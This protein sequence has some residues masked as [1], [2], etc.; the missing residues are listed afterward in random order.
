VSDAA[1]EV[2]RLAA[3]R[4]AA[5]ARRDFAKADELRMRIRALGY[6]PT[7]TS[8]G[9]L[10]S[11]LPPTFDVSVQW[12]VQGWPEDIVRG[13]ES[14]RTNEGGRSVQHVVVATELEGFGWPDDIELVL[15]DPEVGWATARNTGLAR[16]AGSLVFV[17]DGSIEAT[18]DVL[19][20][21]ANALSDPAI[22]V[23]GPYGISTE[24][25]R[26]FHESPGPDVDAVEGYLM[27]FRREL[28]D[29]GLA[30]DPKFKFY[31]TADIELS[32]QVKAMGLRA[33]VTEVPVTKH[34]HRM[35]S[36]TP[37]DERARLS[38]K[39]FYRFLDKWRDRADLLVSRGGRGSPRSPEETR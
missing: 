18:G 22:G 2:R 3:E 34:V 38:K 20:P 10:L 1:E 4:D 9:P 6:E 31:R 39:N 26:E 36:T 29:R 11:P 25:L 21:L 8:E 15:V 12:L 30:F 23:T 13:I 16:A 5:R 27:A 17:V 32:F 24:D 28:L 19:G 33:T 35:W 7:D 37:E 14:F